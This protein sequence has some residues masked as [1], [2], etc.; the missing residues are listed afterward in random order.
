[1]PKKILWIFLANTLIANELRIESI[2]IQS[3]PIEYYVGGKNEP[4]FLFLS[5]LGVD[6][7][8]ML[9]LAKTLIQKY[10]YRALLP[11]IPGQ[12]RTKRIPEQNY[13]IEFLADFFHTM[14]KEI[15][16]RKKVI[17]VGNSMGG[18]IATVFA[19][20]YH[21]QVDSLILIN[22]AGIEFENQKPYQLLPDELI[23]N[24]KNPKVIDDFR[25]NNKIRKDIQSCRYYIL[26][27]Y[28]KE[29]K[30]HTF[31]F[32]G[33]QDKNIPYS[34][35]QVWASEIPDILFF[36]LPG[37]HLLQNDQPEKIWEKFFL[38]WRKNQF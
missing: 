1:M 28:L 10:P 17:L 26:N 3:Y 33:T 36:V 20:K 23:I 27:P 32:W 38:Y 7:N 24:E 12:G 35:S 25:W 9:I 2:T 11:D 16:P 13:S 14:L 4:Y 19:L 21:E 22:P 29:V 18:H 6:K 37:G 15:K 5:G 30:V 34:Y 31:L 8:S